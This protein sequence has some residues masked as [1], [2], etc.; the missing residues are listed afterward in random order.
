MQYFRL[1]LLE[2]HP[3]GIGHSKGTPKALGHARHLGTLALKGHLGTRAFKAL[4]HSCTRGSRALKGHLGTRV[5]KALG[6]LGGLSNPT[7][8]NVV[9]FGFSFIR[10]HESNE[11]E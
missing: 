11:S 5:L 1:L 2:E 3:K 7:L 8:I 6:H 9:L 10:R 4:W